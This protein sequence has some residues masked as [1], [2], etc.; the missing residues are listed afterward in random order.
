MS[1][2]QRTL[3]LSLLAALAHQAVWAQ[4]TPDSA[5]KALIEQG[6]YWQSRGRGDRA[7]ESWQKLLR[8]DPN[9]AEALYGMALVELDA[10]RSS[11]ASDY[12]QRLKKSHPS[13]AKIARLEQSIRLGSSNKQLDD[14]RQLA[15][16]GQASEAVARYQS[17]LDNKAPEGPLA[18]EYYQTLGGTAQGWEE[19]R[20][21]L[22]KLAKEQP[23]DAK[24]A[25]ALAQHLTYREST[26]REGIRQLSQLAGRADAVSPQATE[27][28]RKALSWLGTRAA[29]VSLYQAYLTKH[30]DDSGIQARI[31]EIRKQQQTERQVTIANTD[32]LRQRTTEGFKALDNGDIEAA[33][34]IFQAVLNERPND[35]DA[36]GGMGIIRLKQEK[37]P[38]ALDLLG[39]ASQRGS[40]E[41]W[42]SA[43]NSASYWTLVDQAAAARAEGNRDNAIKLLER[44]VKIDPKEST[45]EIALADVLAENGQL[46]TAEAAY[47]RILARQK[48]NPDAMR[49]L[50]GVMAQSNKSEEALQLIENMSPA[51]QE[52][53]GALGRLRA[54]Q[55][56]GVA[57]AAEQRG[58]LASA[59][60]A[61]EDALLYDPNSP[62]IRL[63]LARLYLKLGAAREARGVMDG[64]LVSNPDMPDALY[65]SALLSAESK[66]WNSGL[67]ALD[68]IPQSYRTRDMAALQK[69]LWVHAQAAQ[70]S[71][72]AQAGQTQQAL[73]LLRGA[74]AYAGQDAEL[75]GALALSYADAGDTSRALGLIRQLMARTT[76]PDLG[77]RLQ[78]AAILLKT[79]QDVELAGVLRQMQSLPMSRSEKESFDNL[80]IAYIVRQADALRESGDLVAAYDTLAPALAE[81]PDDAQI[82][83][84]WARMYSDAGEHQ[85]ALLIYRGLLERDPDN[86]D[87]LMATANAAIGAKDYAY[88]EST[89]DYVLAKSPNDAKILAAAGRL[90]RAQGKNAKAISY[91][92]AALAAENAR[93]LHVLGNAATPAAP[94]MVPGPPGATFNR[95]LP[96]PFIGKPGQRRSSTLPAQGLPMIAMAQAAYVEQQAYTPPVQAQLYTQSAPQTAYP[97]SYYPVPLPPG[98]AQAYPV[99]T[100]PQAYPQ[101]A[102]QPTGQVYIPPPAGATP[103]P[104][105]PQAAPSGYPQ[106]YPA[107][108][109]QALG[110]AVPQPQVPGYAPY[111]PQPSYPPTPA[112]YYPEPYAASVNTTPTRAQTTVNSK[113]STRTSKSAARKTTTSRTVARPTPSA[114]V[115]ANTGYAAPA[116]TSQ[117]AYTTYPNPTPYSGYPSY[118]TYNPS[119]YPVNPATAAP[120]MPAN[121][122]YPAAYSG[123]AATPPGLW[124]NT[125]AQNAGRP[126]TRAPRTLRDELAE[127]EQ[128]RSSALS[129]SVA[130]RNR[131]GEAGMSK[132][133]DLEAP[134]EFRF[135]L[136]DG[137]V[138]L[139]ATPVALEGGTL[140]DT[141]DAAS[142]FGGGPS[143]ALDQ[144]SGISGPVGSQSQNGVG[145]SVGYETDWLKADVGTSPLGFR[146]STINGG[147]KLQGAIN[148]KVTYVLDGSRRPVTD[149]LLSFAGAY[150]PRTGQ[151]WGGVSASGGRADLVWDN[152]QY[153][154]YGYASYHSLDGTNVASNTRLEGGGGLYWRLIKE[155]DTE[156]TAGLN[157]TAIGYNKNL[158]YFTYGHGGY[159]SPQQFLA[160]SIPV[161]W[162]QRSG[163]LSYQIK[164]ALGLQRFKEDSAAFF[165]NNP[166][167]QTQAEQAA[168]EAAS[169][170]LTSNTS[171]FYSGQTKTGL[172]YNL[173]AVM[174]YQLA[175]Q[176]FLG[177]RLALDNASDYRQIT[178]GVYLRYLMQP[179]TGAMPLPVNAFQSPYGN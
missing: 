100:Y 145:L 23:D 17:A 39:R 109:Q 130:T 108:P 10:G 58:D 129:G 107:Y 143:A 141:Y 7:A 93:T 90:Y 55:A 140:A 163:K 117:P 161:S 47:R 151:S 153:G 27:S 9:Q 94:G 91:F 51:Q 166:D 64:L 156:L 114:P 66:D 75:L 16:S 42:H 69:R 152:G 78:Y 72:L 167:L 105:Y 96:N 88:A 178:G 157:V 38:E 176:L 68:R 158:R 115:Y 172:G 122:A 127:L 1:A 144:E 132:L 71:D 138:V 118:P 102:A 111:Y 125:D 126:A 82:R 77:I 12:L 168:Q 36:L 159:F 150:D 164:G 169:A 67:Q 112:A 25:L 113:N 22:E 177:G 48:D 139:R 15:R 99:N 50:V 79:K 56:K 137:K 171:A 101:A 133:N 83:A 53:I 54:E 20:R 43:M 173:G 97:P 146:Y 165:P 120:Q 135:P 18:L 74:E 34:V 46:A 160:L 84:T 35:G 76:R 155:Q 106:N 175:P 33:T 70:A 37:F 63:D 28:W 26:R 103:L 61:L 124:P 104:A 98:T 148:D 29:D 62:W 85:E 116:T 30:P 3:V 41:R 21:G 89:L 24:I 128:S 95:V 60:M 131:Q 32:P 5:I 80:R 2:R 40:A 162:Q 57:K 14:A 6:Q 49:G 136:S 45:A 142:R 119:N 134:V 73:T 174:E 154:V 44:A 59:R 31:E 11:S 121:T 92:N 4:S 81:R 8:L 86:S 13:D 87:L 52:Q 19:A 110:Y 123:Y 149:S 179:Y 170:G 147:I 65:A